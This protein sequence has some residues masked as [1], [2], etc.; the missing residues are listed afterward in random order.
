MPWA[1]FV[2]CAFGF[3]ACIREGTHF[4]VA[5]Y[6]LLG[7]L[8]AVTLVESFRLPGNAGAHVSRPA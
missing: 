5:F 6:L 7:A 2:L 1:P 3:I 8:M 4:G